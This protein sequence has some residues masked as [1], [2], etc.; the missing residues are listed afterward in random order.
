MTTGPEIGQPCSCEQQRCATLNEC[1][2]DA[3]LVCSAG[4]WVW[5]RPAYCPTIM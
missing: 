1:S 2:L 4:A 5:M 3:S